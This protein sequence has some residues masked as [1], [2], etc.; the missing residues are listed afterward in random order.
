MM[1]RLEKDPKERFSATASLYSRWRPDYP[2][3][4]RDYLLALVPA[5]AETPLIADIGCGTGISTRLL[6]GPGRR[7]IGIDPNPDMLSEARR[8]TPPELAVEY[9]LGEAGDT[10]LPAGCAALVTAAQAFHWFDVD[11]ALGEFDRIL[12]P[13]GFCAAFWNHRDD[14]HSPFLAEYQALLLRSSTEYEKVTTP[15]TAIARLRSS[16]GVHG[17]R[18]AEFR[19]VQPLD[20]EGLFGRAYS[21]SYVVHG[22]PEADRPAFDAALSSLFER[23]ERQGRIEFVYR[24]RVIAFQIRAAAESR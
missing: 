20:R 23:Y 12:K 24:T 2:G 7:V 6:A 1:S 8:S 3:A 13:G 19:H 18:E 15:E 4:L 5:S 16:P 11:V 17:L 9:R 14:R 21:S 10:G 22:I